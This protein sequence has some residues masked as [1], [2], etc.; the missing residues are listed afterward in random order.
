MSNVRVQ[1]GRHANHYVYR[2]FHVSRLISKNLITYDY[3]NIYKDHPHDVR[4]RRQ[5]NMR[6]HLLRGILYDRHLL[7]NYNF[8]C[9][10][11]YDYT[12]RHDH[13]EG[14][15]G[16]ATNRFRGVEPPIVSFTLYTL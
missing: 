11:G 5:G 6:V 12:G 10:R 9:K 7:Y 13:D 16:V 14:I 8:L 1:H 3:T 15:R 2:L 4:S